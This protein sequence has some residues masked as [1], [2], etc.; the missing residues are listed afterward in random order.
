MAHCRI[1]PRDL[2]LRD[3]DLLAKFRAGRRA[4]LQLGECIGTVTGNPDKRHISTSDAERAKLPI[5]IGVRH[6]ARL[7]NAFRRTSRTTS[8][9]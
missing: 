7:T 8:T 4:P 9:H 5:R 6:F 1:W 3:P 2:S